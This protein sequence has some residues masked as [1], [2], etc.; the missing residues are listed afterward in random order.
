MVHGPIGQVGV[1]LLLKMQLVSFQSESGFIENQVW[2]FIIVYDFKKQLIIFHWVSSSRS[3]SSESHELVIIYAV[4]IN[5]RGHEGSEVKHK[6]FDMNFSSVL[7]LGIVNWKQTN[8][9]VLV[10]PETTKQAFHVSSSGL[11]MKLS[12]ASLTESKDIF[13]AW[14]RASSVKSLILAFQEMSHLFNK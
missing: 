10:S 9:S 13:N 2:L 8:R 11:H 12:V 1:Y 14:A 3:P 7:R 6:T 5:H 4:L